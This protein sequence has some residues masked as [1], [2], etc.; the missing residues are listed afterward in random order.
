MKKY[1]YLL[2]VFTGCSLNRAQID[3]DLDAVSTLEYE[4][5]KPIS[6]PDVVK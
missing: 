4:L 2:F 5:L 6:E 1:V 3:K